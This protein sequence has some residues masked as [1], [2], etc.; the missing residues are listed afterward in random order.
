MTINEIKKELKSLE[1]LEKASTAADLA[2]DADPMNPEVEKVFDK[3]YKA[4]YES[5]MKISA[6]LV[7]FSGGELKISEARAIVSGKREQLKKM[8]ETA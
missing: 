8:L 1:E 3:A 4:E 7:E 2:Y 6:A 5:F